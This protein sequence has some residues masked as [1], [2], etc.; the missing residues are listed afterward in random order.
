MQPLIHT[1]DQ[2]SFSG[3]DFINPIFATSGWNNVLNS[4]TLLIHPEFD[5][6]ERIWDTHWIEVKAQLEWLFQ[7]DKDLTMDYKHLF[8]AM[9]SMKPETNPM[10][11]VLVTIDVVGRNGRRRRDEEQYFSCDDD[12]RVSH[13]DEELEEKLV[14]A[15]IAFADLREMLKLVD[16]GE[17]K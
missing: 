11:I 2:R 4:K 17:R 10:R 3:Q 15:E 13:V 14:P 6:F 12:G 1:E 5:G 9:R 7:D 16:R 8:Y